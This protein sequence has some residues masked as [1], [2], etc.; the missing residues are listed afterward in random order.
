MLFL[1]MTQHELRGWMCTI[2]A[3]NLPESPI[4]AFETFASE[5][6]SLSHFIMLTFRVVELLTAEFHVSGFH[7]GIQSNKK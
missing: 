6:A 5:C 4:V 7:Q 1:K 2:G 3:F